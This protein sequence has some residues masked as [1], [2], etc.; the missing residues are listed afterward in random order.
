MNLLSYK[1]SNKKFEKK[2]FV[3]RGNIERD[4]KN[5]MDILNK[6]RTKF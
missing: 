4:I 1:V 5:T 3:I 6:E 2:G